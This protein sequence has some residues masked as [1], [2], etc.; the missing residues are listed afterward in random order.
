M[1]YL[2]IL[3]VVLGYAALQ[4][5]AVDR[6]DW[7][8]CSIVIGLLAVAYYSITRKKDL[9]PRL[10]PW[11]FWP[12]ISLPC[13]VA[14][15]A[16]GSLSIVPSV[17][18][19]H[20][21]RILGYTATFLIVRDLAWQ[22]RMRAWTLALPVIII[23]ALEAAY[24]LLLFFQGA[25]AQDSAHGTYMNRNH[26]SGL[27]EM[28]LPL[29][30]LY[31]VALYRRKTASSLRVCGMLAVA[32]LILVGIIYS[33]SRMGFAACL[34][35]LFVAGTLTLRNRVS[36]KW[37][38]AGLVL[39][40]ALLAFI[41]LPPDQLIERFGKLWDGEELTTEGRLYIWEE[42]LPLLKSYPVFG[43]GLGG[44]ESAFFRYQRSVPNRR[45]DF[46]HNDYLQYL[47]ELGAI[48]FV[49]AA[50]SIGWIFIRTCREINPDEDSE[51]NALSIGCI[52]ALVAI[53][54]HSFVDFN[55]YVPAN[56][57][58]MAWI[59]GIAAGLGFSPGNQ[60]CQ[61]IDLTADE[62]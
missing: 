33:F 25:E 31:A 18:L 11:L 58:T 14:L 59:T 20:L 32:T 22:R 6:A 56:A 52:A 7:L 13:Y 37:L 19:A 36:K 62:R 60:A 10:E 24:G 35:S 47:V 29:A 3:T 4:Y 9:A 43:C 57:M 27:L 61:W 15:Q 51:E 12:L 55:L 48:G 28:A 16:F 39:C 2:A 46:A 45:V 42:A 8:Y 1:P 38:A 5:G 34:L 41:Y 40:L 50:I 30:I 23:A 17:T 53:L 49:I 44:F 54:I 26:F 21:L